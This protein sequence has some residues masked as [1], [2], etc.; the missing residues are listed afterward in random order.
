MTARAVWMACVAS[1]CG[2]ASAH[3]LV[4]P[5]RDDPPDVAASFDDARGS[6]PPVAPAG[7]P[8]CVVWQKRTLSNG[9]PLL[10]AERRGV[11]STAIAVVLTT[12]ATSSGDF[13]D[14]SAVRLRLLAATYLTPPDFDGDIS[15]EC[16]RA[17]CRVEA[18]VAAEDT[19]DAL[20]ALGHWLTRPPD[21][22]P[23]DDH[24]LAAARD[25][26]SRSE[27]GPGF[28]L[29]RNADVLAFGAPSS[30]S[31]TGP[32]AEPTT[33]D[34]REARARLLRPSAATLVIVGDVSADAVQAQAERAFGGWVSPSVEPPSADAPQ[35]LDAA[36]QPRVVYV[37]YNSYALATAAL[38]VRGPAPADADVWAFRV[39]VEALG[40]GVESELYVHV[41][42]E[43]AAAYV[44]GAE[45][46]WFPRSSIALLG[47]AI[48]PGKVIAATRAML[49]SVR[50]LRSRGPEPAAL[51]RAKAQLKASLQASMSTD[52]L[53]ASS[54]DA[55]EGDVRPRD[56]CEE[57]ARVDAVSADDVRAAMR[58][59]FAEKRLGAVVIADEL[60]LD[61]WPDDLGIG[62]ARR[63]DSFGRD[64]PR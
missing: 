45:V 61:E 54:V 28:A 59:Y 20:R 12:G 49:S 60:Q 50:A 24:R 41:R 17:A 4:A 8:A 35:S 25:V 27:D 43:L 40:G 48:E 13:S 62:R 29:R 7:A 33:A 2:C 37:P 63:R 51:A 21:V 34:L 55:I 23:S 46:R 30:A 31:D 19:G 42:E 6:P 57:T 58:V 32:P 15:A 9:V 14:A 22:T 36:F 64:L 1:L 39:A 11:P 5:L 10:V 18:R 3:R 47:G 56:L 38:V 44:A 53:V 16:A 26:L 52:A